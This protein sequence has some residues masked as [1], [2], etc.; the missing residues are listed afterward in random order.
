MIDNDV[1]KLINTAYNY[2]EIIILR[3]KDLIYETSEI[4]K[5]DK[6]LKSDKIE[7]LIDEKYKYL[8][9]LKI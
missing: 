8:K 7:E 5:N 3:C 6:L 2:A 4:L 1:I 9:D